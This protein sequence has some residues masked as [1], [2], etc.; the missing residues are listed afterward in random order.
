MNN[1][2]SKLTKPTKIVEA[3]A[4]L[5]AFLIV[6]VFPCVLIMVCIDG[7]DEVIDAARSRSRIERA[8]EQERYEA[9]VEAEY[10]E[11]LEERRARWKQ[12]GDE[13]DLRRLQ[14]A[15]ILERLID[16]PNAFNDK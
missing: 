8:D 2:D 7:C 6:I 15:A 14:K 12:L 9:E 3:I 16:D 11:T 13:A 4:T 5:G 1:F 10:G